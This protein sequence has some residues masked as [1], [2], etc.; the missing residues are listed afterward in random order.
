MYDPRFVTPYPE[1]W[2]LLIEAQQTIL[3]ATTFVH[4]LAQ[5]VKSRF[6]ASWISSRMTELDDQITALLLLCRRSSF[7]TTVSPLDSPEKIASQ[8]I[9]QIAEIKLHRY[10]TELSSSLSLTI[11]AL[12][13]KSTDSAPFWTS[14]SS[15]NATV[16]SN[17][18]AVA[19]S[20]H[21]PPS[22]RPRRTS[23]FCQS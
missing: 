21:N 16:T 20:P 9:N 8:T 6:Q 19:S 3:E 23:P 5:T 1:G 12:A 13:S 22:P 4:D 15:A 14:P 18:N 17:P 10:A 2:K 11:S 7:S